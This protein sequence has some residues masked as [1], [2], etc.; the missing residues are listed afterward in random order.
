VRSRSHFLRLALFATKAH[1]PPHIRKRGEART[2][3]GSG[4]KDARGGIGLLT[5]MGGEMRRA[6]RPMLMAVVAVVAVAAVSATPAAGKPR[7]TN[8]KILIDRADNSAT[9]EEQ[10][11]TVDPDGTNFTLLANNSEAGQWSWDGTRI[12]M[13]ETRLGHAPANAITAI[14]LL[15]IGV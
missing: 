1:T 14:W 3:R 11:F 15:K 10:T 7:G 9:G 6:L 4:E 5:T 13:F 2:A 12:A 8:G